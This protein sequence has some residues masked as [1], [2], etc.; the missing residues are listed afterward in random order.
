MSSGEL[1]LRAISRVICNRFVL[2]NEIESLF[3]FVIPQSLPRS[4][5]NQRALE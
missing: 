4:V 1:L 3:G 5:V 2:P